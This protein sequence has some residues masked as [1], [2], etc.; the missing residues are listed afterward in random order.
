MRTRKSRSF[1]YG[2]LSIRSLSWAGTEI[3]NACWTIWEQGTERGQSYRVFCLILTE[4]LSETDCDKPVGRR[5]RA[6]FG[7]SRLRC[8]HGDWPCIST[9]LGSTDTVQGG[10][11][12]PSECCTSLL[13]IWKQNPASLNGG[14]Y[15]RAPTDDAAALVNCWRQLL[16]CSSPCRTFQLQTL[17]RRLCIIVVVVAHVVP[18]R[19][20]SSQQRRSLKTNIPSV[21]ENV[22]FRVH[23]QQP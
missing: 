17:L 16:S 3:V 20:K 19:L 13:G 6:A 8:V 15:R 12:Y 4:T 9:V 2:V 5:H 23:V 18:V 22:Q 11:R 1:N 14:C 10:W 21:I 7:W